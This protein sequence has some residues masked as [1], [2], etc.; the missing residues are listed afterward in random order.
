[1]RL[2][3]IEVF[4]LIVVKEKF[5]LFFDPSLFTDVAHV[6][7]LMGYDKPIDFSIDDAKSVEDNATTKLPEP[8]DK[9]KSA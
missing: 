2:P 3:T 6:K 8:K 1:V 5:P 9:E 7:R 4:S